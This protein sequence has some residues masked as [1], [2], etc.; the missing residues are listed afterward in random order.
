M[1]INIIVYTEKFNAKIV[2]FGMHKY[3]TILLALN[4]TT[5]F[6]NDQ[7]NNKLLYCILDFWRILFLH[8]KKNFIKP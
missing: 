7:N 5:G 8:F 6:Y 3:C 1:H 4:D 2:Q